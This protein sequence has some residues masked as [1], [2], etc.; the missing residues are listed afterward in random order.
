MLSESGGRGHEPREQ[1]SA[2]A[3]AAGLGP[4]LRLDA[5]G[6][7][8]AHRAVRSASLV[9]ELPSGVVPGMDPPATAWRCGG[10]ITR[11]VGLRPDA[12]RWLGGVRPAAVWALNGRVLMPGLVNAH[13][14]L[15][16]THVGPVAFD[17]NGGFGGWVEVVRSA[18]HS[19]DEA[20]AASVGLGVERSLNGGVVAIGD[21]AGAPGGRLTDVPWRVLEGS[22]LVGVSFLEFF[23]IGRT[24]GM[25]FGRVREFVESRGLLGGVGRGMRFGVQ[26]HAPT[27][28]DR[29]VYRRV[30]GWAA[31]AGLPVATHLAETLDERRFVGRGDGPQREFL[32]ALGLWEEDVLAEVGRGAHPVEHLAEA[33]G[34]S[35]RAGQGWLVAHVNDAP[36]PALG[37][38]A[39]CGASVAYC[40]RAS[41][42]FGAERWF[43]GHRYRDMAACGINVCLGTDSVLNLGPESVGGGSDVVSSERA[44]RITT[45][46]DVRLLYRRDTRAVLGLTGGEER[47]A[48]HDGWACE[49]VGMATVNGARALGLEPSAF[50]FG[51]GARPAGVVAV[52]VGRAE[53][54]G[55]AW[56][57]LDPIAGALEGAGGASLLV[58]GR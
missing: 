52:R 42:Y 25:A 16:L 11:F 15:D 1:T 26:P 45:L 36:G 23:G 48:A 21:I 20:I 8:D 40:P 43:G 38:L 3:G 13:A 39:G 44:G 7:I 55:G 18:R 34:E 58:L 22:P 17:R 50:A 32:A 47:E 29:R 30:A 31:E 54:E 4:L 49:L 56:A 5:D 6:L 14:H 57:M 19:A 35:G 33:M 27:T 10:A 37:V 24:A 51:V 2:G 53:G 28:V 12:D 9:L 46:D 41:A